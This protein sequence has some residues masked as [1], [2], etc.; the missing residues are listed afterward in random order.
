MMRDLTR[1]NCQRTTGLYTTV[2]GRQRARRQIISRHC[3]SA[4]L[5]LTLSILGVP[6]NASALSDLAAQMQP[7]EWRTF[8]T[9]GFDQGSILKGNGVS[10]TILEYTD[11]AVRNPITKKIYVIGC[12]R[13][14]NYD[15]GTTGS[16]SAGWIEYDEATNSWKRMPSTAINSAFH[17]YNHATINPATGDYYYWEM[18]KNVK[19]FFNGTLTTLPAI[20]S[21]I[22]PEYTALEFFPERNGLILVNARDNPARVHTYSLATGAWTSKQIPF[23]YSIH[24]IAKYSAKH[25]IVYFGGGTN[26]SNVLLKM[27]AQ[28]NVTQ[29]ANTPV[30]IGITSN[31]PVH[32]VDPISGNLLVMSPDG[33]IYE[34]DPLKDIWTQSGTHSLKGS[35]DQRAV[36]V[37][38]PEYGVNMVIKWDFGSS[39]VYL[40]KHSPG[41]LPPI[42]TTPP[43]APLGTAVQ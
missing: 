26:T 13:E 3:F 5:G 10:G 27:D 23:P 11:T 40:Y 14:G 30:P 15:C 20:D 4:V 31:C 7:G 12:V 42:D 33:R 36:A 39:A 43:A 32:V 41:S 37:P 2:I 18:G 19:K 38:L 35:S 29:A 21:S 34:Y 17:G 9:N 24:Q 25:K 8:A 28:G 16:P 1:A 22:P 6:A